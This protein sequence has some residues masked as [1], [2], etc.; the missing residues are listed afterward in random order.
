MRH[1]LYEVFFSSPDTEML[2]PV[3]A[4]AKFLN[5]STMTVLAL[6]G[7]RKIA[8]L[9]DV[10]SKEYLKLSRQSV[11]E[12]RDSYGRIYDL[13]KIY[14]TN[15]DLLLRALASV[16]IEPIRYHFNDGTAISFFNRQLIDGIDVKQALQ[17]SYR[18]S[19][20]EQVRRKR[21]KLE[22]RFKYLSN[23][24]PVSAQGS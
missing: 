22:G 13:A 11:I 20:S 5:V 23:S 19:P 6:A 17:A 16:G 12:F 10:S 24:Y 21:R 1:W 15:L 7:D 8:S 3:W 4:A 9:Q 14:D 2:I 18:T